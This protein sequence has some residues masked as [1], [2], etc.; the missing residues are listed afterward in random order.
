MAEWYPSDKQQLDRLVSYFLT[1]KQEL[2]LDQIH[3]LIT[4]HAGYAYSGEVAGKAFS[5]LK[6]VKSKKAIIFGP[7]HYIPLK[8]IASLGEIETPLG[9]IEIIKNSFPKI[10]YEHSIENQVPFIQNINPK[11]KLLPLVIG[12]INEKEAV[13]IAQMILINYPPKE[14]LYIFSTDLSHFLEYNKAK[15][16]DE[17]TI[18]IIRHLNIKETKKLD[19]CGIYPLL[20]FMQIAKIRS[21]QP[22]LIEYKNSGDITGDK[23][24]VVGYASFVF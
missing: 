24:Q 15:Q 21:W 8:G 23:S 18:D 4:P 12:K 5:L 19:A 17:K 13:E 9:K 10:P 16:K 3:G 1:Q 20:I 2:K 11:I 6:Q 14:Y 22:K 7:S